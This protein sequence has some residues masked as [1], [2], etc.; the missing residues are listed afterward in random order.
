[1]KDFNKARAQYLVDINANRFCESF[2]ISVGEEQVCFQF[3][4]ESFLISF[5]LSDKEFLRQCRP[6][7]NKMGIF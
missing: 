3:K 1:M 4:N 7:L 2:K 6:A 5:D